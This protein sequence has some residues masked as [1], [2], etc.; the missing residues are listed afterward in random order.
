MYTELTPLYTMWMKCR[1]R[2]GPSATERDES[3]RLAAGTASRRPVA[4]R[5]RGAG[6]DS[7]VGHGAHRI[8]ATDGGRRWQD[9]AMALAKVRVTTVAGWKRRDGVCVAVQ[10]C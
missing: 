2:R 3:T 5:G 10:A 6:G 4:R 8:L 7:A 1:R 9:P